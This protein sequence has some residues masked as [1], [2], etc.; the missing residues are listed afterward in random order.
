MA[1][2]P[3]MYSYRGMRGLGQGMYQDGPNKPMQGLGSN[4]E[5]LSVAQ[6]NAAQ[7]ALEQKRTREG[8]HRRE[9]LD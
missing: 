3:G 5:P 8:K 4:G 6:R 9:C 7:R 2:Y 1:R